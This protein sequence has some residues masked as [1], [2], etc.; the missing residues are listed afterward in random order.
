VTGNGS[1]QLRR[2][3]VRADD[4]R[5]TWLATIVIADDGYFSTVSDYGN[6]AY[7]WSHAGECFRSFLAQLDDDYLLSKAVKSEI[8]RLRRS[9]SLS[10]DEANGE[11]IL[12]RAHEHLEER[13]NFAT[14]FQE[15]KLEER[16]ELSRSSRSID[17]RMFAERAWP[18]FAEMLRVELAAEGKDEPGCS[19]WKACDIH[20]ARRAPVAAVEVARS[21]KRSAHGEDGN[22]G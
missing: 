7:Y 12:L 20:G 1:K 2:Y 21:S 5:K 4:A 11:W 22:C 8:L 19:C 17:A 3:N 16:W 6:Y 13:E 10:C 9:R 18:V 14:W 15:S